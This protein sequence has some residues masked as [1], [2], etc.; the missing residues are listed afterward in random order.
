MAY[1]T[2]HYWKDDKWS[3]DKLYSSSYG[4]YHTNL[5]LEF[6]LNNLKEYHGK[7][8]RVLDVGGGMGRFA[9]PLLK[10]GYDITINEIDHKLVEILAHDYPDINIL[11]GD[12]NDL[13]I[14]HKFDVAICFG[15][16]KYMDNSIENIIEKFSNILKPGGKFVFEMVNSD[17]FRKKIRSPSKYVTYPSEYPPD[18]IQRKLRTSGF[19]KI[20]M[21]GFAAL[22]P[23]IRYDYSILVNLAAFCEKLFHLQNKPNVCGAY[24]VYAEKPSVEC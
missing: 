7:G 13:K 23:P 8:M 16:I 3:W 19:K 1:Q 4:R 24:L 9:I 2:I 17:S 5:C 10:N 22:T 11:A 20:S 21:R 12:F 15:T 14:D 18:V 6:L